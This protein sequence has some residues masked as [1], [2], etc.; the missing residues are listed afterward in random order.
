MTPQP[1]VPTLRQRVLAAKLRELRRPTGLTYDDV[2]A[3]L[4]KGWS[5]SKLSRFENGRQVPGD[6]ELRR[7]LDLYGVDDPQRAELQSWRAKALERGWWTKYTGVF[8]G[9]FVALEDEARRIRSWEPLVIP[10]LLQ[11]AGY[12]RAV[13]EAYRPGHEDIDRRVRARLA[14][15]ALLER[16]DAPQLHIVIHQGALDVPVGGEEV[17]RSQLR[18]LVEAS[19]REKIDI[20]VLER[21]KGAHAGLGGSF[22]VFDFDDADSVAF[23]DNPAIGNVYDEGL[24]RVSATNLTWEHIVDAALSADDSRALMEALAEE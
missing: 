1:P 16:G 24:D 20:R 17:M 8:S 5:S 22:V 23:A 4:G 19:R 3:R 9:A 21:R 14:R 13:F 11:T 15:Q 10:G 18:H 6:E 2:V 12:A 7:L